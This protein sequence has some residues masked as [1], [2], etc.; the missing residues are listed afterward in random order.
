MDK[1]IYKVKH[2]VDKKK[3][4][5]LKKQK[6]LCIW[7]TGMSASGKSTLAINLEKKLTEQNKHCY[8]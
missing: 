5:D 6:P 4:S 1:E 2:L 8:V 3:R 7:L